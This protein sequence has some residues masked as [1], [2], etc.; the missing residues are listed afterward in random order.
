MPD[1][2]HSNVSMVSVQ[3]LT[4]SILFFPRSHDFWLARGFPCAT[5]NVFSSIAGCFPPG[6]LPTHSCRRPC[7]R[8]PGPLLP[9]LPFP[10]IN[11]PPLPRTNLIRLRRSGEK[12]LLPCTLRI[13]LLLAHAEGRAE[14]C[15]RC[16]C[17]LSS[18]EAPLITLATKSTGNLVFDAPART[19]VRSENFLRDGARHHA[20]WCGKGQLFLKRFLKMPESGIDPATVRFE[21]EQCPYSK[22]SIFLLGARA[23]PPGIIDLYC[24]Y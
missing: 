11:L 22:Y 10:G 18:P 9:L 19:V 16:T 4:I 13:R 8:P 1:V 5:A 2:S 17:I 15:T 23:T 24:K 3:I 12:L 21:V 7:H 6:R 14:V 20:P